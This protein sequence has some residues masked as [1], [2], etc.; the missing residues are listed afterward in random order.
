MVRLVQPP[1]ADG[2]VLPTVDPVD[3]IIRK[4]QI[5]NRVM[6]DSNISTPKANTHRK[7]ERKK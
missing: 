6:S 2:M 3:T 4:Y 1:V 5:P 7:I